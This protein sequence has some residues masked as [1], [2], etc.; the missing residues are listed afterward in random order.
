MKSPAI[1][2]ITSLCFAVAALISGL[3]ASWY[4]WKA[5]KIDID[6]G[7]SSGLPGDDRPSQPADMEGTGSLNGWV[8]ATMQAVNLSSDLNRK[9]AILTAVSVVL[10]GLSSVAGALAGFL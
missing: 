7:W 8:T 9:A 2:T 3:V 1:A 6:P 5:S 10:A 4:W